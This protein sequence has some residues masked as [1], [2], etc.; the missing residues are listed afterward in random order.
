MF[1]ASFLG[2]KL[3]TVTTLQE[4]SWLNLNISRQQMKKGLISETPQNN[5]CLIQQLYGSFRQFGVFVYIGKVYTE[6]NRLTLK[7]SS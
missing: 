5:Y 2:G 6:F 4:V 7:V 3:R 1:L